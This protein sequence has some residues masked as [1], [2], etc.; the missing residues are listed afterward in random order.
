VQFSGRK[1][2]C[3][4]D[5]TGNTGAAEPVY[6]PR[7]LREG[8]EFFKALGFT[9]LCSIEYKG[10][11]EAPYFIEVTVGRTDWWVMCATINGANLHVAAYNDLTQSAIPYS[12]DP[13]SKYVWHLSGR[14]L[15]VIADKVRHGDWSVYEVLRYFA[16]RK[17]YGLLDARDP[18]PF[19]LAMTSRLRELSGL[20][21]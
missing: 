15:P 20:S 11:P 21:K 1:L 12:S 2:L 3:Y 8:L 9:G 16:R 13:T 7:L 4:P 19:V 17:K 18:K 10:D 6:Y 5:V 14:A